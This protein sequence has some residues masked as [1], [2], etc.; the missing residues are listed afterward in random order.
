MVNKSLEPVRL[1][2]L[3][4]ALAALIAAAQAFVDGATTRGVVTAVLGALIAVLTPI[5]RGLVTPEA[6][7]RTQRRAKN[8]Q[9]VRS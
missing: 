7:L 1:L 5:L 8:V 6:K 3:P 2:L 4:L 9:R